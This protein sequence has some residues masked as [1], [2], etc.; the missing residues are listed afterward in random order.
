MISIEH[1]DKRY[2]ALEF[3]DFCTTKKFTYER[4]IGYLGINPYL[5]KLGLTTNQK[6]TIVDH[7]CVWEEVHGDI[8]NRD[9]D[10]TRALLKHNPGIYRRKILSLTHKE[11]WLKYCRDTYIPNL[12]RVS[13]IL[14]K[15]IRDKITPNALLMMN[16]T[17]GKKEQ[18]KAFEMAKH[19]IYSDGRMGTNCIHTDEFVDFYLRYKKAKL[20]QGKDKY[21]HSVNVYQ[22]SKGEMPNIICNVNY[23][24]KIE[25]YKS[26]KLKLAK[27]KV[28]HINKLRN[29]LLSGKNLMFTY[30]GLIIEVK[31]PMIKTIDRC[32]FSRSIFINGKPWSECIIGSKEHDAFI[33]SSG[34]FKSELF[35][36][37]SSNILEPLEEHEDR[38]LTKH[39]ISVNTPRIGELKNFI[40]T[41]KDKDTQKERKQV[42]REFNEERA[43]LAAQFITGSFPPDIINVKLYEHR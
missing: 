42:L 26:K 29:K 30:N 18:K 3:T 31:R 21:Y 41:Y 20:L 24:S 36:L 25:A 4:V 15:P 23:F 37:I 5:I 9:L 34:E 19:F 22:P 35:R 33:K 13:D 40:V 12:Q 7:R 27:K 32:D 8:V 17:K 28:M 38:I 14:D 43:R 6:I 16:F 11:E 1:R 39:L 10:M 2:Q